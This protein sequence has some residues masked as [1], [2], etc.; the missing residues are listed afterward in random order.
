MNN[1]KTQRN[2]PNKKVN[3]IIYIVFIYLFTD[4]SDMYVS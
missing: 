2:T 4:I 3:S 1:P